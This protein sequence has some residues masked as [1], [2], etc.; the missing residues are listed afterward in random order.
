MLLLAA[1]RCLRAQRRSAARRFAR[2]ALERLV[3]RLL[4]AA[5][6]PVPVVAAIHGRSVVSAT[7]A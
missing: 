1:P 4:V 2:L 6:T 7:R 3:T 5:L